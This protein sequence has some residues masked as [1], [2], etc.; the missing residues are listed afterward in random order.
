MSSSNSYGLSFANE[1]IRETVHEER[2]DVKDEEF[3]RGMSVRTTF[4]L[5][6]AAQLMVLVVQDQRKYSDLELSRLSSI[7]PPRRRA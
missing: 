3:G 4:F 6:R 1:A 5:F 7:E 2:G